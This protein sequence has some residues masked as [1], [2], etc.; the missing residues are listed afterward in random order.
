MHGRSL[1]TAAGSA[2]TIA[3]VAAWG[4]IQRDTCTPIANAPSS[5]GCFPYILLRSAHQAP[6]GGLLPYRS[7]L[8]KS[9]WS[10]QWLTLLL[11]YS[12][13]PLSS[14]C[15]PSISPHLLM[16]SPYQ[17]IQVRKQAAAFADG[18]LHLR[19]VVE[20]ILQKQPGTARFMLI[21]DQWEE[22][23]TLTT[24]NDERR[25][26]IDDLLEATAAKAL[27]VVL[28]LRGDFVGHTLTYRPLSD[29]LQDAQ[30]N[31]GPMQPAELQLAI[32]Q[33]AQKVEASFEPGLVERILDD[34]GEEPDNLPLLEFVLQRLWKDVCQHG[35][36]LRHHAYEA[37]DGVK[38]ALAKNAEAEYEKLSDLE[39]QTMQRVFLQLVR[40]APTGEDTRRR[41]T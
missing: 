2:H 37:M 6:G 7:N 27:S 23:Y 10:N 11:S 39:K 1:P 9:H 5:D 36:R 14:G 25:R 16:R 8:F 31:L 18:S 24:S 3:A 20:H 13:T 17:L 30:V 33:P 12:R 38:G 21:V 22:L 41:A 34:V 4:Q 29:R 40:P 35:G 28:T 26:F 19:D 15:S 32:E